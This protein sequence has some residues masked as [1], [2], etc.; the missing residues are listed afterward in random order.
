MIINLAKI[1]L[2]GSGS[3]GSGMSTDQEF[4]IAQ[5][6]NDLNT[7]VYLLES[8]SNNNEPGE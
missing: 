2:S 5:A 6:L 7:R 1:N 8:E 3:G 4:V